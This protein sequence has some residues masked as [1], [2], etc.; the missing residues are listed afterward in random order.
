MVYNIYNHG[1][2]RMMSKWNVSDVE[3][4]E[5]QIDQYL[6]RQ[7]NLTVIVTLPFL[8]EHRANAN[9]TLWGFG[10][11]AYDHMISGAAKVLEAK[12]IE[13]KERW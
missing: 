1:A 5:N 11:K 3:Q 6:K 9:S 2:L 7:M 12:L 13:Y 10:N 4:T 8:V